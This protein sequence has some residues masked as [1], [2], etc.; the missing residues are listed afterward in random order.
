VRRASVGGNIDAG[1]NA[2]QTENA[3]YDR[4]HWIFYDRGNPGWEAKVIDLDT[5]TVA[6]TTE[7]DVFSMKFCFIDPDVGFICYRDTLLQLEAAY[8]TKRFVWW[9]IPIETSG[10]SNRQL[11]NDSIRAFAIAHGKVLFD[12]ADIESHNAAGIKLVDGSNRELMCSEWTSDGGHLSLDGAQRVADAWWWLMARIAGWNGTTGVD[13][14]DNVPIA[15]NIFQ[16]YPNPFNPST[17]F[18]FYLPKR[19]HA[20]LKIFDLLGREVTTIVSEEMSGGNYSRQWNATNISSGIYFY[21]L[22]AGTFTETKK[23]ILLR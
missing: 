11:F 23:L 13:G 8:P 4:S 18:S 5:F 9:T 3:K 6:H 12:M 20:T 1:L 7:Y 21:R 15:Y 2:I 17:T 22:Q 10:N 16:N 19:S 14:L